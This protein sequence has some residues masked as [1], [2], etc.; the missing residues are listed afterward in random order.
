MASRLLIVEDDRDLAGN[1]IDFLEIQGYLTDYAADGHAALGLLANNEYDLVVLD[2]TLPGVDGLTICSRIRQQ[3]RSK[4]P[5]VM[6]TAKDEVDTKIGAFDIGADDYVVK[7]ASLR[8]IEARIRAL[9]RRAGRESDSDLLVVGDLRMD[10]G[11]MKI[12]RAGQPIVL[13]PVPTRI[14]MLLMRRSPNVVHRLGIHRE[15]WGDE[16]GDTHA[17]IVHMHTLRNA[18]DKPFERQLIHTVRGFGY[19]IAYEQTAL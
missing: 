4:V 17:L 7:P 6:L 1:L 18:V 11:T 3:L 2:I 12:E 13:A 5:V 9:I 8:E 16:P 14:L 19:R 15:I 10:V